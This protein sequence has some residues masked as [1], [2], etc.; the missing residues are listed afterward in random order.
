MR[1]QSRSDSTAALGELG[2]LL[3]LAMIGLLIANDHVLKFVFHNAVTGKLSDFAICF[4]MPL[5]VSAVLGLLTGIGARRRLWIG[6]AAT[7]V[8]F[9]ALE[10]S[11]AAG[12]WFVRAVALVFGVTHTVLTRDPTDL[13]ALLFVPLAVAYGR[14]RARAASLDVRARRLGGALALIT[15]SLALMAT[16]A[17]ERCSKWSPPMV[18]KVEGD[19]GTGGLV[20]L[21]ADSYSG[22][23]TITNQVALLAPPD[24]QL[25]ASNRYNGTA[26]PYTLDQGDWEIQ[27]GYCST[28]AYA[29][30]LPLGDSDDGGIDGGTDG[31]ASDG[32][33]APDA[34]IAR[35]A[36][37]PPSSSCQSGYRL[38]DATLE[39]DGLWF[40]CRS[41]S[42]AVLCRSKLTV[43]QP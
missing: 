37:A 31:G 36:G 26:C 2:S 20:V 24:R 41:G 21:E 28:S 4:L 22:R 43:V 34:G 10:M 13:L 8:I 35:D 12:A 30:P 42:A 17:P 38:C 27:Y 23:V 7:A 29:D 6:A 19:C 11:D 3:P 14:W 32:G 15:G 39:S 25:S 5:L 1:R 9:S 40:T 16:T 33:G 18:F